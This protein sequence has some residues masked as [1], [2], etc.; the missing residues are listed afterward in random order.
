MA[1]KVLTWDGDIRSRIELVGRIMGITSEIELDIIE[2]IYNVKGGEPVPLSIE[3][4]LYLCVKK[5][6]KL[7]TFNIAFGRL[8][9]RK[10]IIK[11]GSTYAL[12]PIFVGIGNEEALKI[13]WQLPANT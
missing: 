9:K 12:L 6:M 11:L 10:H 3:N 2:M 7:N 1:T 5:G 13:V 4:R 8:V